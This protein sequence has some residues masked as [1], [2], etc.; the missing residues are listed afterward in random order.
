MAFSSSIKKKT[1]I[2]TAGGSY[3]NYFRIMQIKKKRIIWRQDTKP[4]NSN[5]EKQISLGLVCTLLRQLVSISPS[6][7]N[8]NLFSVYFL[9][10]LDLGGSQY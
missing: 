8:K 3:N 9:E 4:I 6:K 1:H 10:V 7:K 5:Q 2:L